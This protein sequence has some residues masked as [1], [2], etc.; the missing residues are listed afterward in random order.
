M[1][2]HMTGSAVSAG[3][4]LAAVVRSVHR[5][6]PSGL[7]IV[8]TLENGQPQGLAVSAFSSVSLDP[9]TVMVLV[10]YTSSNHNRFYTAETLCINLVSTDQVAVARRFATSGGDKFAGVDWHVGP[11]GAPILDDSIGH[12]EIAV[13]ERILAHT[14]T[15]FI[16]RVLGAGFRQEATPLIYVRGRFFDGGNLAELEGEAK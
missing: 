1:G 9:P 5:A 2:V 4:D 14:H 8:T 15:M 6:Y 3:E 13:Q 11:H 12:F 10:A 7:S 16:G